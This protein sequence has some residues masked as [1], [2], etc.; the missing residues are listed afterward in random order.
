MLRLGIVHEKT[1]TRIGHP[2]GVISR[3]GGLRRTP[4]PLK[5]VFLQDALCHPVNV[6]NRNR[7]AR[8]IR[9][10]RD[11]CAC[12]AA[13]SRATRCERHRQARG[14][15]S[16]PSSRGGRSGIRFFRQGPAFVLE[17]SGTDA[18]NPWK[19]D[20]LT[21]LEVALTRRGFRGRGFKSPLARRSRH[22]GQIAPMLLPAV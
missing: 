15:L 20:S 4:S 13:G 19:T 16:W 6:Q 11:P 10:G 7:A 9:Y 12:Q 22:S 14:I 1:P 2:V 3:K 17:N 18:R 21:F 5:N 8:P